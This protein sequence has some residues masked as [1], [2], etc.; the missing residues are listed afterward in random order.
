MH[1]ISESFLKMIR[2]MVEEREV[3]LLQDAGVEA[4]EV[5]QVPLLRQV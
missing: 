5:A 3:L 2:Q 1:E 4:Y